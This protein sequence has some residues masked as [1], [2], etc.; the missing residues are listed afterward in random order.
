M[1]LSYLRLGIKR[2][3]IRYAD[4]LSIG[5]EVLVQRNE[6]LTPVKVMYVSSLI[7]QGK[8]STMFFCTMLFLYLPN[9]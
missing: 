9:I 3:F 1:F 7:K 2:I 8:H 6:E 4:Q 5:D